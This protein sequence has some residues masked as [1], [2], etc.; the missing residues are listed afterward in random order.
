MQLLTTF[1]GLLTVAASVSAAPMETVAKRDVGGVLICQGAN[2]TGTCHYE[3]YTLDECHDLPTDLSG[4]ASTF[5]PDG[6]NFFCFPK[7][8]NCASICTSPTGCTFGAVDFNSPVKYDLSSIQWDHLIQSFR[9][10]LN[11]TATATTK[12]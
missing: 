11:Q 5:A 4:N 8:G 10:Q 2:A 7:V 12:A 1:T 3:K 9:C 6:D